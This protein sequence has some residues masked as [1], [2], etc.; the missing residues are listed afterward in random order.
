MPGTEVQKF[1]NWV[2][3][4]LENFTHNLQEIRR[5]VGPEVKI[6][7]VVKADAYGHGAIEISNV[8]LKNGVFALGVANADEGVQLRVSG[9][10]APILILGPSTEGEIGDI[11]KYSLTPSVSDL[12]FAQ[13]FQKRCR[14]AEIKASIHLEVDTGMGRGG[15]MHGEALAIIKEITTFPNIIIEGIFTHLAESEILADYNEQQWR[16]FRELLDK[17]EAEG[18]AIPI[19]HMSNSGAILNYPK[20]NLNMVRPGLMSYGIYPSPETTGKAEL[21]PVMSFKTRVVLIK[22]FPK[23]HSIGYGR[24]Y[25]T[26]KTARIATIP[27]GYGDGY[28][29]ILSNRGEVLIRGCR[30]PIVGRISMD[31]CTVD[32]SACP[33][34]QVGDEVVLMGKQGDEYIS[35]N[36]IAQKVHTI[37]YDILC[38]LGKRAPR[39]FLHK[40]RP[41]T[42]EPRL[43]RI[44]IPSEEKSISR[45]DNMIRYCFQTRARDEE[46]GD[47]IYYEMF[48]ALFGKEDRPLELRTSFK[49]AITVS[50]GAQAEPS[51]RSGYLQV[52]THI[53]Y[54]KALKSHIFMIGCALNN[55]QL[56]AFFE[57]KFCEYRWLIG[58]NDLV[59][60]RDFRV[61][62]VRIDGADIP[63]IRAET[64][65]RGYEVWCGGDEL[66]KKLN[67][68][69]KMEIEILTKKAKSNNIFS[70]YLVYPTRGMEISFDYEAAG[71][72]NVREIGFF[73]GK[74]PYPE[75]ERIK[76]KCI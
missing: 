31:M 49:Y 26:D 23:G 22:E 60:E 11:I 73:A 55:E 9:I 12:G 65:V 16:A 10:T 39:V 76:G 66:K 43:R 21:M 52:K 41:N 61:G 8:A 32:V 69:A 48:E 27:V 34:C 4:E 74:H 6:L 36:E 15:M 56:A 75:V 68:P 42:V 18:I 17:L 58:G 59:A 40:G 51:A 71:L 1:R 13:E 50:N 24:S 46:L 62:R 19:R 37:S 64:T 14:K 20:F 5:L 28:G 57:D 53:E 63:I 44:F 70:V 35:A 30:M 3:V 45:I 38:A 67:R 2:E 33:N 47:A 25:V 29:L 7:Q 54:T 72:K